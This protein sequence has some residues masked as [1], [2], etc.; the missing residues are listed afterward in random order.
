MR[1]T[2]NGS[3]TI[4]GKNP[5]NSL[6]DS[7][8]TA[9]LRANLQRLA[10]TLHVAPPFVIRVLNLFVPNLTLHNA[11]MVFLVHASAT[12]LWSPRHKNN[13]PELHPTLTG[14]LKQPQQQR[15]RNPIPA[16]QAAVEIQPSQRMKTYLVERGWGGSRV[17]RLRGIQ[18]PTWRS[19]SNTSCHLPGCPTP[20]RSLLV[21]T[22]HAQAPIQIF[23][24]GSK[25]GRRIF[26][27]GHWLG[28]NWA[29]PGDNYT[30]LPDKALA[31]PASPWDT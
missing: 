1:I 24:R 30:A 8:P 26:E 9:V 5:E 21:G 7:F 6:T 10:M 15:M 29:P 19:V 14:E 22:P 3:L 12:T 31:R 4:P 17:S 13:L 16:E 27:A 20:I 28:A 11:Y 25:N 23:S 18:L 2:A